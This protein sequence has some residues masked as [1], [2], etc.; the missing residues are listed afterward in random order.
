MCSDNPVF[1]YSR[2]Q[3]CVAL[4]TAESEYIASACCAQES[5]YLK[6]VLCDFGYECKLTLFMDNKGAICLA[7]SNE[8]SKRSKH[9]DIRMHYIKDLVRNNVLDIEYVSSDKNIADICT[10]SL[11]KEKFVFFRSL[12]LK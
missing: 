10:K 3:S 5:V 4:S 7:K 11:C 1:W 9:I 8:N 6:G 12:L 2:K